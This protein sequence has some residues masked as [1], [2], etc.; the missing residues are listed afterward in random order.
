MEAGRYV[1]EVSAF[2]G[3]DAVMRLANMARRAKLEY[4][5]LSA[6][7]DG[8]VVRLRIDAS[9]RESEVRWLAA[10]IEKMPEVYSVVYKR[11]A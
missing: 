5:G 1:I 2:N 7:F 10:K 4:H 11:V 8:R 3:M 6:S 9:G